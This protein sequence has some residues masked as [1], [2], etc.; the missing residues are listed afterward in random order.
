MKSRVILIALLLVVAGLLVFIYHE[1]YSK[2]NTPT[3]SHV[4]LG[5]VYSGQT[6]YTNYISANVDFGNGTNLKNNIYYI[7]LS[8]WDSNHSYDQLGISSLYGK[9][10]STYSYT[11]TTNGSIRYIFNPHWFQIRPGSHSLSMYVSNGNVVFKFDATSYTAYTGGYNFAIET[12]EKI[13]NH[14]FSGLTIYEE[15]YGFN[16]TLPSISFNFSQVVFGTTGY[17]TGYVTEWYQFYHNLTNN[18]TSL[19]YMKSDT[20]NIY[21]APS[22]TLKITVQNLPTSAYLIISDLNLTIPGSGQY[23]INLLEGHYTIY[24]VYQGQTK[25]YN[26]T[27]SSNTNYTITA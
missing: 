8:I 13:G 5:A 25:S 19:V 11:E 7:V 21:N 1:N 16:K 24:L 9:F 14:S 6:K 18:Y 10:Y 22:L 12:N 3:G 20:V 23:P 4:Y 27:L 2:P 15:I 17:P 26:V